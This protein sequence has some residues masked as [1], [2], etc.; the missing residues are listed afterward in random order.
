[1]S[2]LSSKGS[3]ILPEYRCMPAA[4]VVMG[5][6]GHDSISVDKYLPRELMG[7]LHHQKKY[8]SASKQVTWY[9]KTKQFVFSEASRKKL[10]DKYSV[11]IS[12]KDLKIHAQVKRVIAEVVY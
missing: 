1:M 7:Q 3:D 4:E 8:F 12:G 5:S 11:F 6:Q 2:I 9:S 10:D